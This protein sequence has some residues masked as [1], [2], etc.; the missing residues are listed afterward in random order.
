MCKSKWS[1]IG[2]YHSDFIFFYF[3]IVADFSE[4]I[5]YKLLKYFYFKLH[6][7]VWISKVQKTQF[8]AGIITQID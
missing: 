5:K 6:H 8:I 4:K 2:D 1:V 3:L 7:L